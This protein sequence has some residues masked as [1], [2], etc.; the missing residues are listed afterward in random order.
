VTALIV[1]A[2]NSAASGEAAIA[3]F[4]ERLEQVARN[5]RSVAAPIQIT[6]TARGQFHGPTRQL[7]GEIREFSVYLYNQYHWLSPIERLNKLLLR[8][9]ASVLENRER[10]DSDAQWIEAQLR[11][12]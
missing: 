9:F 6:M 4:L 2:S 1:K 7:A 10:I 12:A 5:W 11:T 3:P 8:E